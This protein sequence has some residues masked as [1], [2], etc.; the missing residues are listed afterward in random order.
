VLLISVFICLLF[1]KIT[2][3]KRGRGLGDRGG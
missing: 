3:T 2:L 1:G